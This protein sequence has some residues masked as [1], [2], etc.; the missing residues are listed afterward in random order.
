LVRHGLFWCV[1]AALRQSS[2]KKGLGHRRVRSVA[3]IREKGPRPPPVEDRDPRRR[4]R[5]SGGLMGQVGVESKHHNV[6]KLGLPVRSLLL[7]SF[8]GHQAKPLEIAGWQNDG[9]QDYES[10]LHWVEFGPGLQVNTVIL[11]RA[12][13]GGPLHYCRWP[14]RS[15]ML[16]LPP[17]LMAHGWKWK[18]LLGHEPAGA[19]MDAE[20]GAGTGL[21]K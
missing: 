18:L 2:R 8:H 14:R 21:F 7:P 9:E 12:F 10:G 13:P 4:W 16:A 1:W 17:W 6:S 15:A 19:C 5:G 11:S 3:S 20:L